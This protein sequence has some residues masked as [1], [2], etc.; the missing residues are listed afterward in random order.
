MAQLAIAAMYQGLELSSFECAYQANVMKTLDA[1]KRSTALV[2]TG[3][4]VA[5]FGPDPP[6]EYRKMALT[7][8]IKPSPAMNPEAT[9]NMNF[10]ADPGLSH[11]PDHQAHQAIEHGQRIHRG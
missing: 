4:V 10:S 3:M 11:P 1:I 9:A 8:P 6:V 7:I 5:Y 2:T